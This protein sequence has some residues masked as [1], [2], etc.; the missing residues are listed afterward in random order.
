MAKYRGQYS[1]E[2][3]LVIDAA[4]RRT[5]ELLSQTT[6]LEVAQELGVLLTAMVGDY[7]NSGLLEA[8][9]INIIFTAVNEAVL[10]GTDMV[11]RR[12]LTSPSAIEQAN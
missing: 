3:K 1:E 11:E 12:K 5:L 6:N 8:T 7:I 4:R 10:K 2:E 9:D